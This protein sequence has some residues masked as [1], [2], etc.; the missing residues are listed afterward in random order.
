MTL[1]RLLLCI[2]VLLGSPLHALTVADVTAIH[3]ARNEPYELHS[4]IVDDAL[5][6]DM[7]EDM[8]YRDPEVRNGVITA[9][10]Q[11]FNG[12]TI[13][14]YT[15]TDTSLVSHITAFEV[16]EEVVLL[17]LHSIAFFEIPELVER[18][19]ALFD[20]I[21]TAWD[22][23]TFPQGWTEQNFEAAIEAAYAYQEAPN[24]GQY[25][26]WSYN[27]PAGFQTLGMSRVPDWVN[28]TVTSITDCPPRYPTDGWALVFLCNGT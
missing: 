2:A 26:G 24:D 16:D 4:S 13:H 10:T 5:R 12:A 27:T 20:A 11:R 19:I 14:V 8:A 18:R 25:P 3:D 28:L 1:P 21:V 17:S 6:R 9:L 22:P 7:V 15:Q 23:R